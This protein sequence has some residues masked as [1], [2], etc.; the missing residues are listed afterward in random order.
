MDK[1]VQV[2][3]PPQ[4][5]ILK[6]DTGSWTIGLET[7]NNTD[8]ISP[9]KPCELYGTFDN[10][11]SSTLVYISDY[12]ND[13]VGDHG[14]GDI[15]NNTITIGGLTVPNFEFSVIDI[16]YLNSEILLLLQLSI[17]GEHT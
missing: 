2:G 5:N 11:L 4:N 12:Y 1:L 15:L 9:D 10:L 8:C 14:Q 7:P 6:A 13:L 3:T 16:N 17:F